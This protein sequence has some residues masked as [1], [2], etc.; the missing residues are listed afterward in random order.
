MVLKCVDNKV[1]KHFKLYLG[2]HAVYN[3]NSS[4]IKENKYCSDVMKKHFNK[5]LVMTKKDNEDFENST[6]GSIYENNCIVDIKARDY[7]HITGK[8]R[9]SAHRDCN[10][11]VKLSHKFS[12][13][14]HN[15]KN[16][17][18]HLVMQEPGKFN[19]KI[20][21]IPNG[22]EK[23]MSFSINSILSFI[24][25]FQ[26][27]SSLLDNLIKTLNKDDFK[28]LSQKFDNNV[29]DL[30]KQKG[31]YS[32]EYMSDFQMF[33]EKLISRKGFSVH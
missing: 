2:E 6:K 28:R 13:V 27:L 3:F 4:M 23:Y 14:F 12:V 9:G 7:S 11:N 29:L 22:F 25:S 20:N 30:V 19:L 33:K 16:Y 18:L 24:D 15:L 26:F 8:Y 1:S 10:I 5:E 17:D 21:S 31:F 32:Y